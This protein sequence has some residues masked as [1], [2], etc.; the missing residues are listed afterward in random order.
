ML[1]AVRYVE[2]AVE[3][4]SADGERIGAALVAEGLAVEERDSSTLVKAPI[5]RAQLIAWA[6]AGRED[7]TRRV[8]EDVLRRERVV[9]EVR[10]AERD[11]DEWRDMWKQFFKPRSVGPFAIV[12]SWHKDDYVPRPGETIIRLDP[13]RA[14]GTGGHASTRLCLEAIGRLPRARRVLDVGCGSGVLGIAC[15]LRDPDCAVTAIDVDPE[16]V[17]TTV[18]NAEDNGVQERV[19]AATMPLARVPGPFDLVLANIHAEVL[20]KLRE[21]LQRAAAGGHLVL[22]GLLAEQGALVASSFEEIGLSPRER[23][24]DEGWCA[25]VY[26][27]PAGAGKKAKR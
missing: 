11:E 2:I 10:L 27:V 21:P 12:P 26:E 7:E 25:L 20:V 15:A 16:A 24:D 14:F 4:A 8:V 5:G 22:S 19:R 18:E 17:A 6:E 23:I 1:R 13:G 9:A 3:V